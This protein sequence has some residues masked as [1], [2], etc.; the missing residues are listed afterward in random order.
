MCQ[1]CTGLATWLDPAIGQLIDEVGTGF[2]VG[3]TVFTVYNLLTKLWLGRAEKDRIAAMA[4]I[5]AA[6]I[7]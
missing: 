3:Y 7:R 2:V 6:S 4:A 1:T 5:E